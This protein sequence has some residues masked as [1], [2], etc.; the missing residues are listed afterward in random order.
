MLC[1]N[2][3]R[4]NH[5][6]ISNIVRCTCSNTVSST[7]GN[8]FDH[9]LLAWADQDVN[10]LLIF[11]SFNSKAFQIQTEF[12]FQCL[13]FCLISVNI[14]Y[15]ATVRQVFLVNAIGSI[16]LGTVLKAFGD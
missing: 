13:I 4:I 6:G 9:L 15:T 8:E 2:E 14:N 16:V 3:V 10:Q 1:L 7:C 5:S 12:L 11:L